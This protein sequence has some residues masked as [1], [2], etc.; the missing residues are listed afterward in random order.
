MRTGYECPKV[1]WHKQ[2]TDLFGTMRFNM[3]QILIKKAAGTQKERQL[4]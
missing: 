4:L 3:G 2:N 1:I